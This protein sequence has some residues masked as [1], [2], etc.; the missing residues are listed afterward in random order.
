MRGQ[1]SA[2][3]EARPLWDKNCWWAENAAWR[4]RCARKGRS[5]EPWRI[6]LISG[7]IAVQDGLFQRRGHDGP[8]PA[9]RGAEGR[10]RPARLV[11]V[12]EAQRTD[13][14]GARRRG[15]GRHFSLA[16]RRASPA[17]SLDLRGAVPADRLQTNRP[18][19]SATGQTSSV[20][21]RQRQGAG[22][23][24]ATWGHRRRGRAPA[25]RRRGR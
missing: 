16:P 9:R 18:L 7:Q 22:F 8:G 14:H 1:F 4:A 2:A 5:A 15:R 19:A 13:G 23:P 3:G 20:R 17:S 25:R 10:L 21:G 6:R 11:D 12:T 24:G